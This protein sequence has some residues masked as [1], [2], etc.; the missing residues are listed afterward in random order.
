MGRRTWLCSAISQCPL[1][2]PIQTQ[3]KSFMGK[4]LHPLGMFSL[5]TYLI[6]S[7]RPFGSTAVRP[8]LAK[9]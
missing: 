8:N 5:I 2:H 6:S 7:I 1:P 9:G 4:F 3:H